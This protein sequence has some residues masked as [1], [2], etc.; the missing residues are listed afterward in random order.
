[1]L[2]VGWISKSSL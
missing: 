2:G 1:M